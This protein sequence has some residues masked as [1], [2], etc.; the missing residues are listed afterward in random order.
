MP[1]AY[2]LRQVPQTG[3]PSIRYILF[4]FITSFARW[5]IFCTTRNISESTKERLTA[6]SVRTGIS[7]TRD[8]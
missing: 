7:E 6:L 4:K 8:L 1:A 3:A 5:L 2:K